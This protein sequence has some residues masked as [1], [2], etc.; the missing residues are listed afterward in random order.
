ME[1]RLYWVSVSGFLGRYRFLVS[2]M[3]SQYVSFRIL[4]CAAIA[5]GARL[6][7]FFPTLTQTDKH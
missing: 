6:Q 4:R 3:S 7:V 2:N 5:L 1:T